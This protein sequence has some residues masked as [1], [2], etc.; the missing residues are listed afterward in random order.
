M[1]YFK[2]NTL[3]EMM[4]LLFGIGGKDG[5]PNKLEIITQPTFHTSFGDFMWP[6]EITIIS[7]EY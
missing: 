1:E 6:E 5:S 2:N 7:K 3:E 4:E